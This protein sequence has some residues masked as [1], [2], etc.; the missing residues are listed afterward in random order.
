MGTFV[1]IP[2]SHSQYKTKK[3]KQRL[4]TIVVRIF[5]FIFGFKAA[6]KNHV[7][8]FFCINITPQWPLISCNGMIDSF[9]IIIRLCNESEKQLYIQTVY[10]ALILETIGCI[11]I[12]KKNSEHLVS[13]ISF[14]KLWKFRTCF[15]WINS[16]SW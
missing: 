16:C 9:D 3:K 7:C 2:P 8:F 6:H 5:I 11:I 15:Q 13:I 14:S 10:S 4:L 12:I 1:N